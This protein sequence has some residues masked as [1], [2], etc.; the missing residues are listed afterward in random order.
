MTWMWE[1]KNTPFQLG[2]E[3][4]L[5]EFFQ[6]LILF[7]YWLSTTREYPFLSP[8]VIRFVEHIHCCRGAQEQNGTTQVW[9]QLAV[10]RKE[11]AFWYVWVF[12]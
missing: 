5:L 6:Q 2:P 4:S 11:L 3:L 10:Q 12:F 8:F 9:E 1:G 7:K